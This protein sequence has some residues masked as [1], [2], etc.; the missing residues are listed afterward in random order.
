VRDVFGIVKAPDGSPIEGV[1]VMGAD[2]NYAETDAEGRFHLRRPE[3]ALF[4][5]CTGFLPET[6]VLAAG[7]KRVEKILTR[8]AAMRASA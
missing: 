4:F 6:H 2:L 1:L 7:E 5:W 8:V 3:M